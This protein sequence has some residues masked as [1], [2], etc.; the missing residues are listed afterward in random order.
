M[1]GGP[2]SHDHGGPVRIYAA[3]MYGYKS[4]KWLSGIELT[5]GEV[6]GYWEHR[7][8][9]LDGVIKNSS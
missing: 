2:V 5:H 8:Y 9:A 4:T 6:P 3:S 7:G 1:L